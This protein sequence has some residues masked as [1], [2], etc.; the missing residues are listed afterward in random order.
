MGS[1]GG[2]SKPRKTDAEVAEEQKQAAEWARYKQVFM[3]FNKKL[4]K[5]LGD[6]ERG[7]S[8]E[9]SGVNAGV[10]RSFDPAMERTATELGAKGVNPNSGRFKA[11]SQGL[12]LSRGKALGQALTETELTRAG[13]NDEAKKQGIAIGRGI[14]GQAL[15][16]LSTAADLAASEESNRAWAD[17]AQKQ[18]WG[19]A[20]GT[21]MGLAGSAYLNKLGKTPK[22]EV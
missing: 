14:Q 2:S 12:S 5:R 7:R 22:T 19:E 9:L 21:V 20:A 11:A 1:M 13:R 15:G 8:A 10:A 6:E 4:I 17:A 18:A 3:P 16:G